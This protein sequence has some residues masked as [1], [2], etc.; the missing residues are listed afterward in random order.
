MLARVLHHGII[1]FKKRE[2]G[3]SGTNPISLCPQ[4]CLGISAPISIGFH[5]VQE[6][7]NIAWNNKKRTEYWLERFSSDHR[8]CT[9]PKTHH[10]PK[11]AQLLVHFHG[12]CANNS[13][14]RTMVLNSVLFQGFRA[15]Q[16]EVYRTYLCVKKKILHLKISVLLFKSNK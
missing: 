2:P 7:D 5:P 3:S 13:F 6:I 15:C 9:L 1:C 8:V 11:V 4:I 12:T 10:N 16:R 14:F